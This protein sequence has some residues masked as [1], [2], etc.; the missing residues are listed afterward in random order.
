M[1]FGIR[2]LLQAVEANYAYLDCNTGATYARQ[3]CALEHDAKGGFSNRLEAE[4]NAAVF[5][6]GTSRRHSAGSEQSANGACVVTAADGVTTDFLCCLR[7][8]ARRRPLTSSL[9]M[10][11]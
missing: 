1:F 3:Q 9:G 2:D 5:D 4:Y 10:E 11:R 6:D 8:T 7:P